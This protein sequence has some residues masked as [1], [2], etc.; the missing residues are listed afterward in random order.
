[1]GKT[2]VTK[3]SARNGAEA[4]AKGDEGDGGDLGQWSAEEEA[5]ILCS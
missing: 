5:L 1:L 2:N 4:E 3:S